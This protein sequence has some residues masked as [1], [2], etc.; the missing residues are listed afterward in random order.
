MPCAGYAAIVPDF[1]HGKVLPG[2]EKIQEF[3]GQ[4]PPD[5]VWLPSRPFRAFHTSQILSVH[6][7]LCCMGARG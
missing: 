3:L 1:F 4:F 5:K 2:F 6:K 7:S